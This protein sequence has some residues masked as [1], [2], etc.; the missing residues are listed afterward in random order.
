MPSHFSRFSSPSGNPEG[1]RRKTRLKQNLSVILLE[2]ADINL[3]GKNENINIWSRNLK[4]STWRN[5]LE[6]IQNLLTV[7][8]VNVKITYKQSSKIEAK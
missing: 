4:K 6:K 5:E 7:F 8:R 2:L 1:S 3:K